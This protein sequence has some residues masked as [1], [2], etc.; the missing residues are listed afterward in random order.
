[1]QFGLSRG[2]GGTSAVSITGPTTAFGE[3]LT[4][5]LLPKF[6]YTFPYAY[7][8]TEL[9]NTSVSGGSVAVDG[10]DGTLTV[11]S[12]AVAGSTAEFET[13]TSLF[14]RAGMGALGR[15]TTIFESGNES[16]SDGTA[17]V[18]LL[19]VDDGFAVG[20]Q[21]G[22]FGFLHRRRTSDTFVH[23]TSWNVDR[24][25]GSGGSFNKSGMTIDLTKGNV[26]AIAFQYLGFGDC[27]LSVEDPETGN[28]MPVHILKYANANTETSLGIPSLPFRVEV[29]NNTS[30]LDVVVKVGSCAGFVQGQS[31]GLGENFAVTEIGATFGTTETPLLAIRA[32][33][34]YQTKTNRIRSLLRV[35]SCAINGTKPAIV[36]IYK[37]ATITAGTWSDVDANESGM[38]VNTT[39]T[40]FTGGRKISALS[41]SGSTGDSRD[42]HDDQITVYKDETILVTAEAFSGGSGIEATST[43]EW[44]EER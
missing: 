3:M 19:D 11:S 14:Y 23:M 4:A 27:I 7:V 35:V 18:G 28:Y 24:L 17:Y 30:A 6:Q 26:W 25:D 42:F 15:F 40:G 32:K 41:L 13:I 34:T 2:G 16:N 1:M 20:Y 9:F 43:I 36:R 29:D 31:E 44:L 37:H 22:V 8:S 10:T 12:S 38:E 33:S 39:M 21:N 5:H